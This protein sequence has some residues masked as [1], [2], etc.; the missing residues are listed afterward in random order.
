MPTP[1]SSTVTAHTDEVLA[2][3]YN[4]LRADALAAFEIQVPGGSLLTDEQTGACDSFEI[5]KTLINSQFW[6]VNKFSKGENG[7]AALTAMPAI[8]VPGT[9]TPTLKHICFDLNVIDNCD[10]A[11]TASANVTATNDTGVKFE[12]TGSVKLVCAAAF[13][14]NALAAYRDFGAQDLSYAQ[15]FCLWVQSTVALNAGDWQ[16]LLDNTAACASP[17][18]AYDL[19]A[20][21]ASV[22][23]MVE[24]AAGDVSGC[25]AIISV[26][27]K[28]IVDK[29]AMTIYADYIGWTGIAKWGVQAVCIASVE[30]VDPA[31]G[32]A[33][34]IAGNIR[35]YQETELSPV[36]MTAGGTP[37]A[38]EKLRVKVYRSSGAGD[39]H[40]AAKASFS[41]LK[42][43]AGRGV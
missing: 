4:E 15:Y 12:G 27:L 8:W 25:T 20:I 40:G 6:A 41:G 14:A 5:V 21:A 7:Q 34:E 37:A 3:D 36:A 11:W 43:V 26:G 28:Q 22:W 1:N 29:G 39:T 35:Y 19:P 2:S 18:K 9:L 23:T 13:G 30:S 31:F 38:G 17:T 10:A 42:L 33:V 16:L 24:I 32:G